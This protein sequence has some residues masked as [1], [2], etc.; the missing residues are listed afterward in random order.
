MA[1]LLGLGAWTAAALMAGCSSTVSTG[2]TGAGGGVGGGPPICA[3]EAV[4]CCDPSFPSDPCCVDCSSTSAS[5]GAGGGTVCGGFTGK[6]CAATEYCDFPDN[7]CGAADGPGVC[8]PRPQ[9]CDDIYQPTCGCDGQVHGNGCDANASGTDANDL[10]GC[11]PPAGMFG[12]GAIFCQLGSQYCEEDGSDTGGPSF[13]SCKP[14]PA[15]CGS[16]PSCACLSSVVCG[17]ACMPTADGGLQV[18][19]FGG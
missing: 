10:G 1:R 3:L 5:T 12:C 13:F 14:L 16:A 11:T 7:L 4:P 17:T 2:G 19:C 6:P 9:A 18:T 8:T 15:G